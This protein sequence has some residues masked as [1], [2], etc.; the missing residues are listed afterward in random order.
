MD[1]CQITLRRAYSRLS[2]AVQ[3]ALLVLFLTLEISCMGEAESTIR[4][5]CAE[6][7]KNEFP[8]KSMEMM[9][10]FMREMPAVAEDAC[11]PLLHKKLEKVRRLLT[12]DK[13]GER[14]TIEGCEWAAD[15][16]EVFGDMDEPPFRMQR[17]LRIMERC[18]TVVGRAWT[19]APD[20]PAF[21]ALN[22]RLLTQLRTRH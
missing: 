14:A 15:A 1:R 18:V 17:G 22:D 16:M 21:S 9:R 12:A 19:R 13:A 8:R 2:I 10:R 4:Q 6:A 11:M 3:K 5:A 7:A 20:D